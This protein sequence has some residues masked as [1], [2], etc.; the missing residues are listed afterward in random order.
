MSAALTPLTPSKIGYGQHAQP[1]SEIREP[2][3]T[4][5][6]WLTC[7]STFR[8]L[9]RPTQTGAFSLPTHCSSSVQNIQDTALSWN[10]RSAEAVVVCNLDGRKLGVVN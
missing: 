10:N 5:R 2:I 1:A 4:L 8:T 6:T 3:R 7:F 9:L